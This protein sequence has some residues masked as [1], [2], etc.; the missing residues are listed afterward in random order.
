M[1]GRE[2]VRTREGRRSTPELTAATLRSVARQVPR[3]LQN[4][5][6][7]DLR[8]LPRWRRMQSE[9]EKNEKRSTV[10]DSSFKRDTKKPPRKATTLRF[11]VGGDD[12]SR[13]RDA[14]PPRNNGV[15]HSTFARTRVRRSHASPP[16]RAER[17]PDLDGAI[18]KGRLVIVAST[19]AIRVRR[20][21]ATLVSRPATPLTSACTS[22][23]SR[24][25]F[26]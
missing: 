6:R 2:R 5:A 4:G 13:P 14:T 19:R 8:F 1:L 11:S 15:R 26:E 23:S 17:R 25:T 24:D 9:Y 21:A 3:P 20:A 10:Y 7:R 18:S 16:S 12:F 22:A